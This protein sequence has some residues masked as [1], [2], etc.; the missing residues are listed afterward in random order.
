MSSWQMTHNRFLHLSSGNTVAHK[1]RAVHQMR[2]LLIRR[3][4]TRVSI[5]QNPNWRIV[6][7]G[8]IESGG[9]FQRNSGQMCKICQNRYAANG[10]VVQ[11]VQNGPVAP[12]CARPRGGT[13]GKLGKSGKSLQLLVFQSGGG[14]KSFFAFIMWKMLKIII[15]ITYILDKQ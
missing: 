11:F 10:P 6:E 4:V 2:C 13:E 5:N 9:T 1:I 3:R 12:I 7:G 8:R 15:L 14:F